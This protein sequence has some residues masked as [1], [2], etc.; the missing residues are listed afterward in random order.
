MT[1]R[2]SSFEDVLMPTTLLPFPSEDTIGLVVRGKTSPSHDPGALE[3]HADCI[4]ADGSPVGFFGEAGA[5][6][7]GRSGSGSW[8]S[9]G[10]NMKGVVYDYPLFKIHRPFYVGMAEAKRYSVKSTVLV[11]TVSKAQALLFK[12]Y[13]NKL[14]ANPGSFYL[15][16]HNCSTH[17]SDAFIYAGIITGGIPGLDTPNNLYKQLVTSFTQTVS[18]SGFLGFTPKAA[19]GYE[20]AVE[21]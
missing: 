10:M 7:S 14:K 6:S 1:R 9:T 4:L 19:D 5:G 13:W 17:A 16:G 3:Q 18:H 2:P 11:I 8:N 12:D 20:V 15:L 21:S